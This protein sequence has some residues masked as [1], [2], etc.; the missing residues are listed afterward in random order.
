MDNFDNQDEMAL[1]LRSICV[2]GH[3]GAGKSETLNTL[4]NSKDLF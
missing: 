2:I 1:S 3:T 4:A